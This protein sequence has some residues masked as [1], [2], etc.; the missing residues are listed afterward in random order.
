MPYYHRAPELKAA[1]DRIASGHFSGGDP[2]LFQPL[3]DSLLHRDRYLLLADYESYV[4]CHDRAEKVYREKEDWTRMSIFNVA[5]CGFFSSDRTMRQY[6]E[7]I[8]KVEPV[9][10]HPEDASD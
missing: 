8:W 9:P 6:C 4:A 3:V 7:E 1:M 10:V 5:R 2:N